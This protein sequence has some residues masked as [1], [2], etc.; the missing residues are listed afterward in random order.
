M[1]WMIGLTLMCAAGY[2]QA[3]SI[4]DSGSTNTAG[5]RIVVQKS[6]DAVYTSQ[7][8]RAGETVHKA[9]PKALAKTLYDDVDAARPLSRLPT[10]TCMKSASFGT[11]M[12]VLYGDDPSPD[13]NCG[14]GGVPKLDA[15][16]KDALAIAK[17]FTGE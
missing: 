9:I 4:V 5:F 10:H 11:K 14:E 8:R 17:I 1:K 16:R 7:P 2:G 6:G 3:V 12:T 15:L 13:L